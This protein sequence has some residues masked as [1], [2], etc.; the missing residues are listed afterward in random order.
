MSKRASSTHRFGRQ[1][2]NGSQTLLRSARNLFH[3]NL[4]S[5]WDRG[6]RNRLVLVR[7]EHLEQFVNILIA[8]YKYSRKNCENLSKQVPMETS[9][10]LKT[11]SQLLIA[12]LKCPINWEYFEKKYQSN[13]LSITEIIK[14]ETGRYL[15]VQKLIFHAI[16]RQTTY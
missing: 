6:S 7:S 12:F 5:I 1:H 15:N 10:K 14:C 9:L 3:T 8:D 13:T 4:P 11:C 2:V 16:L